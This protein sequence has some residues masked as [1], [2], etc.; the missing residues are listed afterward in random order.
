[1]ARIESIKPRMAT[2]DTR[3]GSSA[4]VE[5]IRGRELTVIRAR[6]L[7]RDEYTCQVCGRVSAELVVDH[8]VPLHLGGPEAD[9]NRQSMCN[10]CHKVKSDR[11]ERERGGL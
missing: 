11:E 3:Q 4:A 10:S 6:I 9:S 2:L 5:R 8:V 1:M 7:L